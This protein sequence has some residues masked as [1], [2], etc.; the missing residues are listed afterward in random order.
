M[1]YVLFSACLQCLG[2]NHMTVQSKVCSFC[3][4]IASK[5]SLKLWSGFKPVH[6]RPSIG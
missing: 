3:N 2:M 1:S 4:N 5:Y 6:A